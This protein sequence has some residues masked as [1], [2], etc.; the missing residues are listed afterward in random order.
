MKTVLTR[1]LS[2]V[3]CLILICSTMSVM[4]F[5]AVAAEPFSYKTYAQN[6]TKENVHYLF[7]FVDET[8]K[9]E[10]IRFEVD[11]L[12]LEIDLTSIDAICST[13]DKFKGVITLATTLGLAGDLKYLELDSFDKG[14]SRGKGEVKLLSEVLELAAANTKLIDIALSEE[15]LDLGIVGDV[16]N[17]ENI[18][19]DISGELK[20]GI[21]DALFKDNA[22]LEQIKA[23]ALQDF[24]RFVYRDVIGLLSKDIT[25]DEKTTVDHLITDVF[26]I[27]VK[28]YVVGLVKD[29]SFSFGSLG[30]RYAVLDSLI[31]V[32]GSYDFKDIVLTKDKTVLQQIN[33]VIGKVIAQLVPSYGSKW[34]KGDY[35]KIGNNIKGLV[36]HIA[37]KSGLIADVSKKSDEALMLEIIKIIF[38]AADTNGEKEIYEAIKNTKTLTEAADKIVIQLSGKDYPAGTTYEQVAGDWFINEFGGT[39]PFYELDG[40]TLMK[41]NGKHTVWDVF[42]SA[43]NFFL[44]DKNLDSYFG[45][46]LSKGHTFFEKLD[47]ILDYTANDGTANFNSKTYITSLINS[48]FTVN[49]QKFVELTAVKALN[50]AGKESVVKFLYN[51]AYNL[52]NNWTVSGGIKRQTT[53]YFD[54]ALTDSSIASI[55]KAVLETLSKRSEATA[56]FVGVAFGAL[57]DVTENIT[58]AGKPADCTEKGYAPTKKCTRPECKGVVFSDS[59]DVIASRGHKYNSGV[60]TIAAKCT[61]DGVKKFT[62]LIC[63]YSYTTK[64]AKLG[65]KG[66]GYKTT[67]AATYKTKGTA[68]NK[69]TRTGCGVT[70]GTKSINMLT[71]NRPT[72]LKAE[73]LSTTSIKYSWKAVPGAESYTVYY[74]TAT[75]SWK[76]V[77][78]KDKKTSVTIKKLKAGLTYKFKVVAVAGSNKSK[79]SAL[80]DSSTKPVAV[81]L[82]AL[83]STKKKEVVVEWKK[84]TGV[85]GYEILHATDKKFK[86]NKKTV[87][88]KKAGTTK[89][90]IK[91][92]KSKKKYYVKVRAYKT[93]NKVKVF[94]A[95][96]KVKS[97]KC[98]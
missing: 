10:N 83:R 94:G 70:L 72:G 88:I 80:A 62:C 15:G 16:A 50:F 18:K 14:L 13:I 35:T 5:G 53:N 79:E 7:D 25:V 78:V 59:N 56:W 54:N 31:Q 66:S 19:I 42:N 69:C 98:K 26:N 51:T 1:A 74:K 68:V 46:K 17:I 44:I 27:L 49:V 43:F 39:I 20:K 58:K 75:G 9:K 4:A 60:V 85:T 30:D 8:L 86:K 40:K 33:D 71:L 82:K 76:S 11:Q 97:I 93:V 22:N 52:I 2:F 77:T 95:Y 65:H 84:I 6:A 28:D 21:V 89:T 37:T 57:N 91:K 92:L 12:K 45:W 55:V 32:D 96:S 23:D 3:M 48:I 61:T 87:T 47:I 64:I 29:K 67:K 36:R 73:A 90:I 24:D 41:A 63:P 34:V 38:Q 81:T